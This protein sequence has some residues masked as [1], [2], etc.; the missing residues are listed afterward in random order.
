VG[1][2]SVK[3]SI[4]SESDLSL[5]AEENIKIHIAGEVNF[6]GIIALKEGSRIDDAIEK[7]GGL[8]E[9][10][11]ISEVNLACPVADGQ[12][13]YIPSKAEVLEAKKEEKS[14][15]TVIEA[16]SLS[17]SSSSKNGNGKVNINT[18][19]LEELQKISGIGESL[20]QRIINYRT[21]NGKFK[22]VE[23]LKNVSGIGDKKYESI[24]DQIC[25]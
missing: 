8:T 3:N 14:I 5:E 18:A 2:E 9:N 17:T 15:E 13:I 22:K 24:K 19:N 20:A 12:K 21:D 23:D 4:D 10:A 25:I 6:N 7:A 11:D 16:S 1:G